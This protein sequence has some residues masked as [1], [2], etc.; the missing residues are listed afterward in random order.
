MIFVRMGIMIIRALF[1][2]MNVIL[3]VGVVVEDRKTIVYR[4]LRINI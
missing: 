3:S 4:V 1:C 2:V